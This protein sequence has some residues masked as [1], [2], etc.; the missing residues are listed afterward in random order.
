MINGGYMGHRI[1][2]AEEELEKQG[3]KT[4]PEKYEIRKS[5]RRGYTTEKLECL[6]P[7]FEFVLSG[8]SE[9]EK[10]YPKAYCKDTELEGF[11]KLLFHDFTFQLINLKFI[12]SISGGV[13]CSNGKEDV[14]LGAEALKKMESIDLENIDL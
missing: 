7:C 12:V 9:S 1:I 10:V 14:F 5:H 13:F 4:F 8:F 11:I 2:K 3:I 6:G